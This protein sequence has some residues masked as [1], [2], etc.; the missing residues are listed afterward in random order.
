MTR[1]FSLKKLKTKFEGTSM[2]TKILK[3]NKYW[4]SLIFSNATARV[5]IL[6]SWYAFEHASVVIK[7]KWQKLFIYY[8]GDALVSKHAR[9]WRVSVAKKMK[10][11][12]VGGLA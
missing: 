12:V 9:V 3:T 2:N 1:L 8:S 6:V 11:A 5:I 10:K 4:T 7:S